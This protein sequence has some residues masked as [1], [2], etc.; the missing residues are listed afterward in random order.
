[1]P[2]QD[3]I[4]WGLVAIVLIMLFIGLNYITVRVAGRHNLEQYS[5]DV[6]KQ[7]ELNKRKQGR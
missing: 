5:S 6:Y 3:L 1:M 2:I 4:G 7:V